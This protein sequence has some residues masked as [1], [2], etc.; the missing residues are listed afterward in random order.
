MYIKE[1]CVSTQVIEKSKFIT[2]L[3][4]C[5]NEEE[6]KEY[7]KLLKKKHYD[8]THVCSAFVGKNTR[9]SSDDGEP[10]GTAGVPML[11]CL[12]KKGMENTA[13]FVVRYF[14]GIKL[15]AGGLIRAY[16]SS[17]SKAIEE[18]DTV[19]DSVFGNFVF[20]ENIFVVVQRQV[21][22]R[23]G[24]AV[25]L[26]AA[27]KEDNCRGQQNREGD[28]SQAEKQQ[29][30]TQATQFELHRTEAFAA[31]NLIMAVAENFLL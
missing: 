29:R 21:F 1:E 6:Y 27:Y 22:H 16:S 26:N 24:Q 18:A 2:Y 20:K 15:G 10:S 8:A 23:K 25:G 11:S 3:E 9:R 30:I 31:D 14:G 28:V 12:D 4:Y 19:E 5:E 17:V 13:V 7:L